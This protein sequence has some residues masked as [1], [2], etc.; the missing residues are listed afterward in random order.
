[1]PV[2]ELWNKYAVAHALGLKDASRVVHSKTFPEP[3][4]RSGRSSLW[5]S[6][7]VTLWA[8][9]N[10]RTVI[11]E[12]DWPGPDELHLALK[13]WRRVFF[14]DV[15]RRA[16]IRLGLVEDLKPAQTF[17]KNRQNLLAQSDERAIIALRRL[18]IARVG[19]SNGSF[20]AA[21]ELL[22]STVFT[23]LSLPPDLVE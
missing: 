8:R 23:L 13:W 19:I 11:D 7:E 9:Q 17:E 6:A 14:M 16:K 4:Y 18:V 12:K 21:Y 3:A 22:S 5:H 1:M 2:L 15:K 20:V 10:N